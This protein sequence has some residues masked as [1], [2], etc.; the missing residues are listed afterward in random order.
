[1]LNP[2]LFP[3]LQ[4]AA[5]ATLEAAPFDTSLTTNYTFEGLSAERSYIIAVVAVNA[6]GAS[7]AVT[8]FDPLSPPF[9]GT[10]T[11]A[12]DPEEES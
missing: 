6:A 7:T 9:Y 3:E 10:V 2:P 4:E 5:E 1:L 8:S 11:T 12:A